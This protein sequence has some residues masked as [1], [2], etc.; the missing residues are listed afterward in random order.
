M[1]KRNNKSEEAFHNEWA[2]SITISDIDPIRQ[3]EGPTSPEYRYAA[4]LLKPIKGKKI[5][6]L[7]CGLGEEVVYLAKKGAKIF[8]IDISKEMLTFTHKLSLHY[9]LQ[10]N[11][12][13]FHVAAENISFPQ[14]SFDAIFA[15]NL[16]HHI[17][18]KK[19]INKIYKVLKTDGTA[20]FLEPLAYNPIINVYRKMASDVRTDSEHPITYKDIELIK[21]YFPNFMHREFHF[22]T[23]LI[24]IWFFVGLRIHPNKERYWK[25]IIHEGRK[26]KTVFTI[27]HKIDNLILTLIPWLA[28]LYWVIVL[29][30][31]KKKK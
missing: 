23:L 3:F 8:A 28:S 31:T 7:G 17:N 1:K 27:L 30:A 18:L 16:L 10:H 21:Q 9:G 13:L 29:K 15:C 4:N 20:I 24:F 2:R 19:G 14:E 11:I 26:Y 12:Q 22:S 5:L 25:K 6:I